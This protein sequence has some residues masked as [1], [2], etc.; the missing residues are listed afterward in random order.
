MKLDKSRNIDQLYDELP[1]PERTI[2]F[3]LRQLI[4]E[5]LEVK[6]EKLAWGAPFYY[7]HSPICFIWPA[8][9]PWGNL[10]TGVALGFW[11]GKLLKDDLDFFDPDKNRKIIRRTFLQPE[12]ID[13]QRVQE[14]LLKAE[15]LDQQFHAAKK[16]K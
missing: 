11:H 3:I 6:K 16:K 15:A 4:F 10:K 1:E 2:A 5:T 9:V 8:S 7:G 13:V 12:D 14:L